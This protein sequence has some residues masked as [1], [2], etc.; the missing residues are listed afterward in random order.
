MNIVENQ[1]I[2]SFDFA[3]VD[4][5]DNHIGSSIPTFADLNYLV[6]RLVHDFSQ[7]DTYVIDVGCSTGRLLKNIKK[8]DGVS[9]L[10][11]EKVM[12]L[13]TST[14]EI[15]FKQIDVFDTVL[16][17]ASV[18]ISLFTMQFMPFAKRKE[19]INMVN[20]SLCEGG[21]FICA[22]KMHFETPSVE[23]VIQ[24]NLLEWKKQYFT[25][26]EILDKIISLKSVMYSQTQ[27]GLR[28]EMSII[29]KPETIWQWGAFGCMVAR[30]IA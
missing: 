16:P 21:I 13:P 10:G 8:R 15:L 23:N 2:S 3:K 19:F 26:S 28:N 25:D 14:E 5:F 11:I 17:P 6:G 20:K 24:S 12:Q 4:G 30:K 27:E 29:G 9:Y 1:S 22:E 7:E 18:I